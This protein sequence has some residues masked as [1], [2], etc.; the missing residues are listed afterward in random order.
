MMKAWLV[1]CLV[2]CFVLGARA[3][4]Q[5]QTSQKRAARPEILILP[6]DGWCKRNGYVTQGDT[7]ITKDVSP[8]YKRALEYDSGLGKVLSKLNEMLQ[9]EGFYPKDLL[10]VLKSLETEN[11]QRSLEEEGVAETLAEGL[12]RNANVS[13]HVQV[14]YEVV[15]SG[16][17]KKVH[18]E[19]NAI[20]QFTN[21]SVAT[22]SGDSP[23]SMS[24]DL[25]TMI[26]S[27]TENALPDFASRLYDH[28][29]ELNEVGRYYNLTCQC[30]GSSD[31]DFDTEFDGTPLNYLIDDW[32]YAN[33]SV[34]PNLDVKTQ[35]NLKYSSIQVPMY[36]ANGRAQT[37]RY[38]IRGLED[39]FRK[40]NIATDVRLKG[41]GGAIVIIKGTKMDEV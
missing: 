13:I 16:L 15:K 5:T 25:V 10:S 36:A 38:W 1:G 29:E 27:A 40:L 34:D 14:D 9:K 24:A 4:A 6:S 33:S 2:S 41:L 28:F 21:Y 26:Q 12:S 22:T 3:Q 30:S 17:E 39:L 7:S 11:V 35:H 19:L 8:D 20:D 32:I 23:A 37:V 31:V 18:V